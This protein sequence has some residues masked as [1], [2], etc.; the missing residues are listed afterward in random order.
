MRFLDT[1]L[2]LRYFT[3][4]NEAKA[5]K[6]LDLLRR[7]EKNEEKVMINQMVIFETVFTLQSQYK[8][9]REEIRELVQG[10][11]DLRGLVLEQKNVIESALSLYSSANI[12]FADAYNACYMKEK[13]LKE[14]YSYDDDFDKIEGIKR[15]TPL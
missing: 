4:D 10:I 6:V 14:I 3:K 8:V 9:P 5:K 7:V 15:V 12:S 1:N 11:L 2:L 13:E